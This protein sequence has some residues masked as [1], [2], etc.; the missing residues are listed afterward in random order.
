MLGEK[1]SKIIANMPFNFQVGDK[2]VDLS[3]SLSLGVAGYPAHG[4]DA[5]TL[6]S[7]ADSE[8]YKAKGSK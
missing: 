1:I 4:E 2:T 3:L 5:E 8:L 6:I 7:T